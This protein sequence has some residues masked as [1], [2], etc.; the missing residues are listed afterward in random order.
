MKAD[1]KE[2]DGVYEEEID[3]EFIEQDEG[4]DEF[5]MTESGTKVSEERE[6][7]GHF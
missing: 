4:D 5:W 7:L 6:F 1:I 2:D 3:D